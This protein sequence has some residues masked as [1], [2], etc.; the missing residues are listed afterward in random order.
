MAGVSPH[1]AGARLAAR[2][3]GVCL[4]RRNSGGK[5]QAW[6]A[7][8]R[9]LRHSQAAGA[10]PFYGRNVG[11]AFRAFR[12]GCQGVRLVCSLIGLGGCHWLAA[13]A[14]QTIATQQDFQGGTQTGLGRH[15]P[16]AGP[17]C[18]SQQVG[19]RL[20][21]LCFSVFHKPLSRGTYRDF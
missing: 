12:L 4:W 7:V 15:K 6:P 9:R 21:R 17:R 14:A 18:K 5:G 8:R 10:V 16:V 19:C 2:V 20:C 3:R 11:S 13:G 1:R